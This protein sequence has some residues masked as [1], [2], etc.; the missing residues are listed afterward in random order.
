MLKDGQVTGLRDAFQ[1]CVMVGVAAEKAWSTEVPW[2]FS[3]VSP[4]LFP[5]Q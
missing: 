1:W 3:V 5:P 4:G 2:L